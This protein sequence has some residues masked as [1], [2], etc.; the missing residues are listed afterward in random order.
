MCSL[1]P[2]C[3]RDVWGCLDAS[4]APGCRPRGAW[5]PHSQ[6]LGADAAAVCATEGCIRAACLRWGCSGASVKAGCAR[7]AQGR[8]KAAWAPGAPGSSLLDRLFPGLPGGLPPRRPPPP[9]RR[10]CRPR[11]PPRRHFDASTLQ[12]VFPCAWVH[13]M[14]SRGSA[15]DLNDAG[16][17]LRAAVPQA[18]RSRRGATAPR[19][20][21]VRP[22]AA[23]AARWEHDG[24]GGGSGAVTPWRERGAWGR[25]P[26]RESQRE[27]CGAAD[28][29]GRTARIVAWA[30]RLHVAPSGPGAL[31]AS[32][33]PVCVRCVREA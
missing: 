23:Q 29:P 17:S 9:P 24:P 20:P 5:V 21:R 14:P 15:S 6:C 30:R 33:L 8:P 3:V 4:V 13:Q 26:P 25:Q 31:G 10:G 12:R 27:L 32:G 18:P 2:G 19:T 7:Y 11:G 22:A 16:N 28:Q 1:Q